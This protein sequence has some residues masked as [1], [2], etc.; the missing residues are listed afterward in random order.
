MKRSDKI[1]YISIILT[2]IFSIGY[3]VVSADISN[4]HPTPPSN[5]VTAAMLTADAVTDPAVSSTANISATK[6][7]VRGAPG[8]V[9]IANGATIATTSQLILATSTPDLEVIGGRISATTTSFNG[10]LEAWPSTDCTATQVLTGTGANAYICKA[11][12]SPASTQLVMNGE[13]ASQDITGIAFTDATDMNCGVEN[14]PQQITTYTVSFNVTAVGAAG[15]MMLGIYDYTGKAMVIATTTSISG[16]GLYSTTTP[17][18]LMTPGNYYVCITPIG[19]AN[20]TISAYRFLSTNHPAYDFA[21]ASTTNAMTNRQAVNTG[22]MLP[23]MPLPVADGVD[24]TSVPI[25]MIQD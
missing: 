10:V 13:M 5:S 15:Q 3:S 6:L 2:A 20:I 7:V 1:A 25:I 16:T 24:N 14:I 22:T 11:P 12:P 4:P 8:G 18:T 19:S 9:L 17:H 21:T 23:K